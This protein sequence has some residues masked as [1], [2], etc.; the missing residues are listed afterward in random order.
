MRYTSF[1]VFTTAICV[2]AASSA[3]GAGGVRPTFDPFPAA[4]VDTVHGEPDHIVERL[5]E[6][7]AAESIDLRWVRIRE[8]YVETRWFDPAT[9]L[10]GGGR[11]LNTD[12]IVRLRFWTDIALTD[13]HQTQVVGEAVS[14]RVVDPSLPVRQT[15]IHV[16]P[17][18]P[19]HEI[20]RRVIEEL[21]SE[22]HGGEH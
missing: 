15:E 14:R 22:G 6:L 18:H 10:S 4:L 21:A 1:R 17:D 2:V 3:C 9:R 7:L 16:P 20:L 5:S 11:S 8:G 12:G 19:G 13:A